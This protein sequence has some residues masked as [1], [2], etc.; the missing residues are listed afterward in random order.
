MLQLHGSHVKRGPTGLPNQL[1]YKTHSHHHHLLHIC[2]HVSC[3]ERLLPDVR[4]SQLLAACLKSTFLAPVS[5]H[6]T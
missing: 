3:R 4:A 6:H 1:D 5:S 2:A